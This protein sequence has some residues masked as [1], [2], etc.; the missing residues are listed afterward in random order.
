MGFVSAWLKNFQPYFFLQISESSTCDGVSYFFLS[1]SLSLSLSVDQSACTFSFQFSPPCIILHIAWHMY[2]RNQ[3]FTWCSGWVSSMYGVK[4]VREHC[5]VSL[6]IIS[7]AC[8]I[9]VGVF[10]FISPLSS[11]DGSLLR[12]PFLCLFHVDEDNYPL[13]PRSH[14]QEAT[15]M[16]QP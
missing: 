6:D 16:F 15:S 5:F 3:A 1:L 7:H 11:F 4:W 13:P 2:T 9:C 10:C 12:S 8:G 14:T